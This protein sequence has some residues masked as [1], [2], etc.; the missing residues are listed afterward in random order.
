MVL[1]KCLICF[2]CK[3]T[4]QPQLMGDLPASRLVPCRPFS[5]VGVDYAGPIFLKD[6]TT[7]TRT[8]VKGYICIFICLITKAVHIEL[9]GDL[10]TK[11]FLN[12]FKRFVSRRGL[13]THVFSDNGANF[14]GANNDLKR[15]IRE[16]LDID[17]FKVYLNQ[18]QIKWRFNCP[19]TAY[20]GGIWES[21]VKSAKYHLVRIIGN[22]HLTYESLNT[23]LCQIESVL[24]SRPITPL[25][26]DPEDLNPLTPSHFL[27]G[28]VLT[29]VP[30]LA[31]TVADNRLKIYERL[32]KMFQH[33]W[34]RWSTEYLTT[35]QKRTKWLRSKPNLAV[36]D[37]VLII[38]DDPYPL[39][40][41]T[42]RIT[43]LHPG[44]DNVVRVVTLKTSSGVTKRGVNKLCKLP[45]E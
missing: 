35:L 43:E 12:C 31:I 40:W 38:E 39:H 2:K 25:S 18:Y 6:G 19:Y 3:P 13:C 28:D 45:I 17:D 21:A 34:R 9:A 1:H 36:G 24:N 14:T 32:Q 15:T 16:L 23:I 33:F 4:N 11:T 5:R 20:Q 37:L 22:S 29:A 41:R 42:G 30:Q 27:I 7:R 10:S 44:S 26:S 8:L